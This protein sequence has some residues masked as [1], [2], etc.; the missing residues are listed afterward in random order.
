M[1]MRQ[2]EQNNRP[3]DSSY[4]REVNVEHG[5][6][7]RGEGFPTKRWAGQNWVIQDGG[8]EWEGHSRWE[9]ELEQRQ[10]VV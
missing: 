5:S 7:G 3:S 10:G 8:Q 6:C 1:A 2:R 4:M 9:V